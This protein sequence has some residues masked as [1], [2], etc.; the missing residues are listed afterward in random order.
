[1][2]APGGLEMVPETHK[3]KNEEEPNLHWSTVQIYVGREIF[4]RLVRAAHSPWCIYRAGR[5][6][7]MF[8]DGPCGS[9][10]LW[11]PARLSVRRSLPVL[12]LGSPSSSYSGHFEQLEQ[13]KK[14]IL[15]SVRQNTKGVK[16]QVPMKLWETVE[17]LYINDSASF[18]WRCFRADVVH[19]V[20]F[21][22]L[23]RLGPKKI[24]KCARPKHLFHHQE[25]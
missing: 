10:Q 1:M 21:L 20:F 24:K 13:S 2:R 16:I 8:L 23:G 18:V 5:G 3:Y 17:P 25:I 14:S 9:F 6:R 22:L 12:V 7:G 4:F 15:F 11:S 19:V